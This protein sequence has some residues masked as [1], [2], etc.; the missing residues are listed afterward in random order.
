[1]E[2]LVSNRADKK[3]GEE[4]DSASHPPS[5]HGFTM[6][7]L[8]Y[9]TWGIPIS[10]MATK[11]HEA[12]AEELFGGG[13]SS[14]DLIAFQEVWHVRER[15]IL[16]NGATRAGLAHHHHFEC[17]TG[18][19]LWPGTGGTGLLVVSRFPF[20]SVS[21]HRF[22]LSGRAYMVHE[23]D[24][25]AAKGVGFIRV[26]TPVCDVDLYN[27]HLVAEY[28]AKPESEQD[29]YHAARVC[30]AF[31]MAQLI[32]NISSNASFVLLCGDLNLNASS[33]AVRIA[34]T[35]PGLRIAGDMKLGSTFGTMDNC[36]SL[37][38]D[39]MTLDYILWDGGD[40]W[41]CT[42]SDVCRFKRILAGSEK[43]AI[44]CDDDGKVALSD[45]WGVS[46]TFILTGEATSR[47]CSF[48]S[49]QASEAADLIKEASELARQKLDTSTMEVKSRYFRSGTATAL[50]AAIF[51][52]CIT[53]GP[54]V[55]T[56]RF[57]SIMLAVSC[58]TAA[59][60]LEFLIAAFHINEETSGLKEIISQ[61]KTANFASFETKI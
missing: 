25:L 21:Y 49:A 7:V 43:F 22:T 33:L 45:H 38:N 1:M 34:R 6:R 23:A 44:P 14:F 59:I 35:L 53:Q 52:A 37:D 9:N 54:P 24:H 30:E 10:P 60:V 46:A 20:Q 17:G 39:E 3:G 31:E 18:F 58:L 41:S 29:A 47:S 15:D 42:H 19:P 26:T 11:R 2:K 13:E 27:T 36:F 40:G 28:S 57:A 8:T 50:L 55:S 5:S 32:R 56:A 51:V 61:M 4:R 48:S 16:I 12:I